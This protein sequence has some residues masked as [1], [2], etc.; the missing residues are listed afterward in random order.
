MGSISIGRL[1][2]GSFFGLL[3]LLR[4]LLHFLILSGISL[5]QAFSFCPAETSTLPLEVYRSQWFLVIVS[6]V[7]NHADDTVV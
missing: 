5:L 6:S 2:A 3:H 1:R 4:W 7:V